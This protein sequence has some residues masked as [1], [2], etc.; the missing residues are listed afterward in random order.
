MKIENSK[1]KR[2]HTTESVTL[3][4]SEINMQLIYR[5]D[6]NNKTLPILWPQYV[7]AFDYYQ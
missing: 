1:R 6:D 7:A 3:I 4:F 2:K 5:L